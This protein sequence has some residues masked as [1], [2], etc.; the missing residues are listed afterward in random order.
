MDNLPVLN[1]KNGWFAYF[2]TLIGIGVVAVSAVYLP[3]IIS[4]IRAMKK[5][6]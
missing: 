3:S 6:K 2:F 1:L 5:E 4:E